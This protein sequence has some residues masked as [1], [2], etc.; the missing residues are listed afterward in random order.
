MQTHLLPQLCSLLPF[1]CS[2]SLFC[3]HSATSLLPLASITRL[4]IPPPSL[5]PRL[6]LLVLF[7]AST[8][9]LGPALPCAVHASLLLHRSSNPRP[10]LRKIC[11][12]PFS[13]LF[14]TSFR[15]LS[16]LSPVRTTLNRPTFAIRPA[17]SDLSSPSAHRPPPHC[18]FRTCPAT[19]FHRSIV[20]LSDC[21][22]ASN[23]F[24]V[25]Y[26]AWQG[27]LLQFTFASPRHSFA[28]Q[29]AVSPS[30]TAV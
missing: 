26:P 3:P 25:H 12:N 6:P 20:F 1:L 11:S 29:P 19:G 8:F 9:R 27:R 10:C 18:C 13:S 2:Q 14:T 17:R 28:P 24:Q 21:A 30:S 4:P 15:F 5:V 22:S 7:S 23:A 16:S